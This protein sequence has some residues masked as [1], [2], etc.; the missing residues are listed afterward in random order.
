MFFE[1]CSLTYHSTPFGVLIAATAMISGK[2][3]RS[4]SVA[5]LGKYGPK[6]II[7]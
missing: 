6:R 2:K 7:E 4:L 3:E 5:S 1:R